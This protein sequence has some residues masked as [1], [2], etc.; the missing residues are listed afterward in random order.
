MKELDE[1]SPR[2]EQ[3]N[4]S[5]SKTRKTRSISLEW[6]N[7]GKNEMKEAK[8]EPE[9]ILKKLKGEHLNYYEAFWFYKQ[10]GNEDYKQMMDDCLKKIHNSN[11]IALFHKELLDQPQ[12]AKLL[13][14]R[15]S[16]DISIHL[17][18]ESLCHDI[19]RTLKYALASDS[20]GSKLFSYSKNLL[21]NEFKNDCIQFERFL[22]FV[23]ENIDGSNELFDRQILENWKYCVTNKPFNEIL[24]GFLNKI[25][26]SSLNPKNRALGHLFNV[27]SQSVY[28]EPSLR[29][30]KC[31]PEFKKIKCSAEL[32]I[33]F[34]FKTQNETEVRVF[35]TI[36][37]SNKHQVVD[38]IIE[39]ILKSNLTDF[40]AWSSK[41]I[42]TAV[43]RVGSGK[44]LKNNIIKPL[45]G[46]GFIVLSGLPKEMHLKK[47]SSDSS[48]AK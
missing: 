35:N 22:E 48:L 37:L 38:V 25:L 42:I 20:T 24:E 6:L 1:P 18:T 34:N 44:E 47:A 33:K 10:S 31:L 46:M 30:L 43:S 23:I 32:A 29:I 21:L 7:G 36:G 26:S 28:R 3:R 19:D 41:I 11:E 27:F 40:D 12:F 5:P 4:W 9:V 14:E 16:R 8:I 17:P 13:Q 39:N 15:V 2:N 45:K